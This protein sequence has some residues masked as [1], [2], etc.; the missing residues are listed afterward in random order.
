MPAG[1]SPAVIGG[2]LRGRLG[3]AGVTITDDLGAGALG[4]FGDMAQRGLLAAA[5]G[6]D[7]LLCAQ[8]DP[9]ADS[10]TDGV[11]VLDGLTNALADGRLGV[12]GA[13]RAAERVMRLRLD[14]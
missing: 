5:A 12:A 7:L 10:V 3:F 8:P 14:T 11:A 6:A 1:L 9:F 4:A 2:E 13:E